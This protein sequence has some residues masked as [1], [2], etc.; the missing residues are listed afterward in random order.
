MKRL[1]AIALFAIC[2]LQAPYARAYSVAFGD[3][4]NYWSGYGNRNR[5]VV[6]GWWVPQNNRDVI[7]T[8]DITGGN[9]I[10]DGHTL[11][12]IQLNYSS[13]SRSL[14][15]GDWFFDTNQDGAWDYVLHHTLRVFGDGSISREEFGYGLFA[16]DD[17]SYE[18]GNRVGY[19][20]SFWPRGAEG[21]HDHPVRAWV[22]LDDVL[23][24]VGYDGW[25][26]WI[27]E[28]SLGETNW[29]DINLDF[30]GIRAFTYGFAMTCGNDVLFGE[31]LVPA[32]E[33]STFLLLGFGGLGL[34]LYGRRR[35]RFF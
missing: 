12:G 10:F 3:D 8:P 33:P 4:V 20:E 5:D 30:S 35:K 28:N 6:N 24:D 29:S 11:S 26:Y 31:A 32:P 13:T 19:Q 16:L 25:D 27:A 1:I 7:G 23:S 14:V 18:N 15:P 2:L 21:R 17:L 9:F 34:L 22:D